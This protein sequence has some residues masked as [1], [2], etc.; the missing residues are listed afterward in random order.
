MRSISRR[1]TLLGKPV[2]PFEEITRR[3]P[4]DDHGMFVA[5]GFR[6][7]NTTRAEIYQLCKDSGYTL[8]TYICS[9]ATGWGEIEIGDNCF[10]FENNVLQPFVTI[11]NNTVLW[12]GNHIG[13]DA[14]VGSHCF[15]TSHTV[16][17]GR[18]KVGDYCFIGVNATLRDGIEV[19]ER[20]VIGAGALVLRNVAAGSVLKGQAA[21]LSPLSSHQL[22]AI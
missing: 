14:S 2:I 16:I 8:I 6:G 13:H 5:M 10:I 18:A 7:V 17:S 22:R 3:Y 19:G 4:P 9:R 20:S 1:P 15:I 12:S 11:G 21:I